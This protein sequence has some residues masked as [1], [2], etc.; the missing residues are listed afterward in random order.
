MWVMVVEEEVVWKCK[1]RCKV[2][3]DF[4]IFFFLFDPVSNKTGG[5]GEGKEGPDLLILYPF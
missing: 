1:Y 4:V 3:G 5:F 2:Q